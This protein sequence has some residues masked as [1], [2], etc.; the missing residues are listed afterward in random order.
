MTHTT[1]RKPRT[2]TP[3]EAF[4]LSGA[5]FCSVRTA[6]RALTEGLQCVKVL[7]LREQIRQAGT[8]L[9]ITFPED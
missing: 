6:K 8:R 7:A 3:P 9:G 4:K 2:A 5:A 1:T